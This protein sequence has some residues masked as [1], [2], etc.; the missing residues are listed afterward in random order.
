LLGTE[1]F[2]STNKPTAWANHLL[3][4]YMHIKTFLYEQEEMTFLDL[5]AI[6]NRVAVTTPNKLLNCLNSHCMTEVILEI[7]LI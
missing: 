5:T 3:S 2:C 1:N 7:N 6:S 4:V